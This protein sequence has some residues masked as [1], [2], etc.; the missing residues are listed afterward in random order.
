MLGVHA[1]P[2]KGASVSKLIVYMAHPAQHYSHANAAM[3]ERARQVPDITFVDLYAEYPRFDIDIDA[4][5]ARLL[6]HDVVLFQ[7][8]MFWYSTPSIIKEWLDLV[9]EHGFAYGTGGDS[10]AGKTMM[11]AVTAAGPDDA[12]TTN[13]YQ[14]YPIRTFLTPLEQTARLC[15]MT[16]APPYLLYASLRA[17]EDGRIASHAEGYGALLEAIRDDSYDFAAAAQHDTIDFNT[18]PIPAEA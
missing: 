2:S 16:F 6:A 1:E 8:P 18:L 3:A 14:H 12:Y 17:A 15:K 11:L 7:F 4:E 10:L 13:G 5:Q 9:L